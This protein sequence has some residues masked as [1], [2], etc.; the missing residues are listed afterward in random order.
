MPPVKGTSKLAAKYGAKLD[1][2]VK[3]HA[4]DET[5]YGFIRLPPGIVNGIAQLTKCYFD[6]YKTGKNKGE[7]YFRAVCRS[8]RR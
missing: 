2:A 7:M 5:D 3:A 1:Q 8:R 4:Q 6:E